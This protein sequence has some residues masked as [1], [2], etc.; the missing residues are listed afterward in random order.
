MIQIKIKGGLGNML[1]QIAAAKSMSIDKN[2]TISII[3]LDEHLI[4]LNN[5]NHHNPSL[6]HSFEY[7][8]LK[9]FSGISVE[10]QNTKIPVYTFPFEYIH[11]E[12]NEYDFIIDGFFQSEK[13][14]KKNSVLIL[15]FFSPT[16]E[17]NEIIKNKYGHLFS[18]KITSIHVR[19]GDYTKNPNYHSVQNMEYFTKSIEITKNDTDKYLIFS[20]DINWC[21]ENFV[22][23][24]FIF[25]ENEKDY[26]E[27][28][29]MSK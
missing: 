29:L 14:F 5:D 27:L 20:D 22:G 15:D 3:D 24:N 13:Y 1:F 23:D 7:K 9:M 17:I 4:M 6:T 11:R 25:I 16:S 12:I 21:K 19:R 28:Y 2:T 26:V 8:K 18:K 10:K